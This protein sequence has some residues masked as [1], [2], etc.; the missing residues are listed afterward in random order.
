MTAFSTR[1]V[2]FKSKKKA[3]E[4]YGSGAFSLFAL[5]FGVGVIIG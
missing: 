4:P 3:P 5:L 2:G 1:P